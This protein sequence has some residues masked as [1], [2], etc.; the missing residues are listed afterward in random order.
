[1]CSTPAAVCGVAAVPRLALTRPLVFHWTV[2]DPRSCCSAIK[3]VPEPRAAAGCRVRLVQLPEQPA[4]PAGRGQNVIAVPAR[5]PCRGP[6]R[7]SA[8]PARWGALPDTSVSHGSRPTARLRGGQGAE[9]P[10]ASSGLSWG[11][12][13]GGEAPFQG[14]CHS[15]LLPVAPEAGPMAARHLRDGRRSR[16]RGQR[17]LALRNTAAPLGLRQTAKAGVR[18]AFP[19]GAWSRTQGP[20]VL[21]GHHANKDGGTRPSSRDRRARPRVLPPARPGVRGR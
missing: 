19:R 5:T 9:R 7:G 15:A 10:R 8:V 18:E 11:L 16:P 14:L 13:L 1:M 12:A 4:E 3:V 17:S 6:R 2:S 20:R 21:G